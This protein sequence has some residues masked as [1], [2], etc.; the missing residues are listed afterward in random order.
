MFMTET[1]YYRFGYLLQSIENGSNVFYHC[2]PVFEKRMP[3]EN[4]WCS[5]K[6]IEKVEL[7]TK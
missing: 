7:K 1:G 3:D 4:L 5:V 6:D 2:G